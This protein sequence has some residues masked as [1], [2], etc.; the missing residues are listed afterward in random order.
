MSLNISERKK[1]ILQMLTE[2]QTI[3]VTQISKKLGVTVVT[4]RSDLASLEADGF[5]VRTHG[6]AIPSRHP[7]IMEKILKNRDI[8]NAIALKAAESINDGDTVIIT[9][10]T[11]TA[12]IAKFLL[13]KKDIHIVTNNTLLL[14]YAQVSP[15]VRVTLIGGEFRPSEEGVVGPMAM[16]VLDQ[17]HV[18]KAFIGIDGASEK[19]GFTAHFLESAELVRKMSNQANE[20]TV[21]S[22]SSK[23]GKPGFAR[24]IPYESAD[25]IITDEGL[26]EKEEM[27][28]L[29]ANV[30]VIKVK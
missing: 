2:D 29:D 5:L 11:T 13:G 19:Q 17:F 23:F 18:S 10:G 26:N 22:N 14:T 20:I 24:I 3:S 7:K 8:K 27:A 25:T 21:L 1:T 12:L 6:G 28:L 15:H 30:Q 16:A 4:T 9:A